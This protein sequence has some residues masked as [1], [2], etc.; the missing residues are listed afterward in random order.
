MNENTCM[1]I[2]EELYEKIIAAIRTT[3]VEV[4][5]DYKEWHLNVQSVSQ[6]PINHP[7]GFRMTQKN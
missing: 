2:Y 5:N 3:F 6:I 1:M 4:S 7:F